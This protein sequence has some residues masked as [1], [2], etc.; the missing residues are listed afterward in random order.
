MT[1]NP[2][3]FRIHG[4]SE[5]AGV[6]ERAHGARYRIESILREQGPLPTQRILFILKDAFTEPEL[7]Q[8]LHELQAVGT[9]AR[10]IQAQQW[11]L[12]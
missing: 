9:I 5:D 3:R 11:E 2:R 4:A 6:A 8:A 1:A 12:A 7:M 10:P